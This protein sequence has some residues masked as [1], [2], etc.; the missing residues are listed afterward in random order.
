M[1]KSY[2]LE[3]RFR[4]TVGFQSLGMTNKFFKDN[5]WYKQNDKGYE[6]KSESLCSKL[7]ECSDISNYVSYE[8]CLINDVPGCRSMNMLNGEETLIT[9]SR[10]Y[11]LAY[12]GDLKLKINTYSQVSDRIEYVLDFVYEYT[13]LDVREYLGRVLKFDM[14]TYDVDRHF[15][16]LAVIKRVDN[17]YREAPMFDFGASFF[18]MQH[19]F[20]EGMSLD[21][22]ISK[23]TP[24]P[25]SSSFEEQAACFPD[26]SIKFDYAS[27]QRILKDEPEEL[28][29]IAWHNFEKYEHEFRKPL[30]NKYCVRVNKYRGREGAIYLV[31]GDRE[32]LNSAFDEWQ[33]RA[34]SD[35]MSENVDGYLRKR[36]FSVSQISSSGETVEAIEDMVYDIDLDTH[37]VYKNNLSFEPGLERTEKNL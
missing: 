3:E 27:V 14:L 8:E 37:V 7:L 33:R 23:M 12:G 10:L 1:I 36:G 13:A 29:E 22:K 16:N 17:S 5:Y 9:F 24:Q 18:S 19:V 28:Q 35:V 20:T 6:G 2:T 25:F 11:Q 31:C 34:S 32:K 15:N 26:V 21:E 30:E 4:R